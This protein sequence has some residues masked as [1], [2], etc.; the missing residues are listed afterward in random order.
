MLKV[1]LLILLCLFVSSMAFSQF[2]NVMIGNTANPEEPAIAI[3]PKNPGQLV[4]G[5]NLDRFYSSGDGGLTW[6]EG[7]LTS[8]YG[9]YGD[10][11][12]LVDTAG[13]Y[14]YFHLSDPSFGNWIDRIVCQKSTDGGLTWTDGT[15]M[16][17]NGTKAQDKEWAAVD[18]Q[19]NTIYVCWT[20]F[21]VYGTSN[22][23]DSSIILF[24]KSTDEG[25][26]W[27]PAKRINRVAGDCV[28]SDNTV[29]GA[30]PAVGPNGEIFVAWAGPVGIVF[31]RSLDQGET[32]MDTNVFVSDIPGGWDYTIP[33]IYRTNGLPVTCCDL[34]QGTYR[35]NIY[36]NWSDQRNGLTDTDIWFA[37]STDDGITWSPRKRVNDD[38]PGKQQF[39]T[40]MTVDQKTGY[41]YFV[42]Y[43]RRAYSNSATDVYMAV[44]RDGGETFQ[45]FKVSES[46]FTPNPVIFFGDYTNITAYNNVIRPIWARLENS[47][48][49]IWTAIVDSLFT[50]TGQKPE[51]YLSSSL[52]QNYPNSGKSYPCIAYKVRR[53]VRVTLEVFDLFGRKIATLVENKLSS[54]GR[55]VEYFDIS[56]YGLDPG[57]YYYSLVDNERSVRRKMIVE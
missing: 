23:A 25:L 53:P 6:Q 4:A 40:W 52:D 42:F 35:G 18:P 50:G 57:L 51:S 22:P 29:E 15:Y 32:W 49:S 14:Y 45:N 1:K 28:D 20:Q 16:G 19:T 41:I 44:S 38:P 31:N 47:Q 55:Y 30:V 54:P 27:S 10:P 21:D 24:S 46:P 34:S 26:T 8:S 48:L 33:N 11:S 37:K 13:N 3:N 43:D 7:T 12:L 56:R 5:A 36:I 9:V 39:F 2:P 17:L